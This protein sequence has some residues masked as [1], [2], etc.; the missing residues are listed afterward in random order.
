[1]ENVNVVEARDKVL[2]K[3]NGEGL[4]RGKDLSPKWH[5]SGE[6]SAT[7]Y[8]GIV[9]KNS[10]KDEERKE[11]KLIENIV[12]NG[13]TKDFMEKLAD[14]IEGRVKKFVKEEI[15]KVKVEIVDRIKKVEK[16]LEA[17]MEEKFKAF[18]EEI[19]GEMREMLGDLIKQNEVQWVRIDDPGESTNEVG[20][21]IDWL[22][23]G[24]GN[25]VNNGD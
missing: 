1:M 25:A 2:K 21:L 10:N 13:D 5:D 6:S 4:D 9:K 14:K 12:N 8:A 11:G 3:N 24:D 23:N 18:K 16:N 7:S 15:E 20:N 19:R 17:K 22:D